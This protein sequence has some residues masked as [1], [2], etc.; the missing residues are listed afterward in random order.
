MTTTKKKQIELVEVDCG[1]RWVSG[2][3]V[4]VGSSIY[5]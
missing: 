1:I 3:G 5:L 4:G 2:V